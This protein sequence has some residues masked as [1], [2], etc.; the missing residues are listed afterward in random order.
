MI[1]SFIKHVFKKSHKLRRGFL[2]D[3][4]DLCLHPESWLCVGQVITPQVQKSSQTRGKK[5]SAMLA[6]YEEEKEWKCS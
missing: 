1:I 4:A 3:D 6:R 5:L 2:A